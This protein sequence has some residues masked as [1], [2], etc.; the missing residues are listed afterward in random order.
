MERV[1]P[2]P[3]LMGV[4]LE[5][6]PNEVIDRQVVRAGMPGSLR[7]LCNRQ[8]FRGQRSVLL[9]RHLIVVS[10]QSSD[11]EGSTTSLCPAI[12]NRAGRGVNNSLII[13]GPIPLI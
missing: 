1:R 9:T 2:F 12:P 11:A 4:G 8:H 5:L 3:V 13:A 10:E 7:F 6:V